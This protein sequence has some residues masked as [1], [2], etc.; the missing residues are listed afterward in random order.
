MRTTWL[1]E[2]L[3]PE[4][5]VTL[6]SGESGSGKSTLTLALAGAV[7]CGTEFLGR[8]TVQHEVLILDRE[9]PSAVQRQRLDRLRIQGRLHCASGA[10]G[11]IWHLLGRH[12]QCYSTTRA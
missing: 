2:D 6:I 4:A 1:V 8:A 10:D 11:S 7:A 12:R 3:I 5:A 9:N